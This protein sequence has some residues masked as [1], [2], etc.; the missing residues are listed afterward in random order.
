MAKQKPYHPDGPLTRR[1]MLE[2]VTHC[3]D[4]NILDDNHSQRAIA[5]F[6][7]YNNPPSPGYQYH[8]NPLWVMSTAFNKA[9]RELEDL[10]YEKIEAAKQTPTKNKRRVRAV[11]ITIE[12]WE[13]GHHFDEETG[14]VLVVPVPLPRKMTPLQRQL[15]KASI[16]ATWRNGNRNS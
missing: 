7:F 4:K 16:E 11:E 10:L 12:L 8:W 3:L 15:Q 13:N 9:Y 2:N 14:E 1:L 5:L 6:S